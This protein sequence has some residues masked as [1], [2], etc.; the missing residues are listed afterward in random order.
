M[1]NYGAV[2]V[3]GFP[4]KYRFILI[5]FLL[6]LTI[7]PCVSGAPTNPAIQDT[8]L[9]ATNATPMSIWAA[10]ALIGLVLFLW[11][12]KARMLASELEADAIISIL[13]WIPLGYTVPTSFAVDRLVGVFAVRGSTGV[14]TMMEDHIVYSFPII[15]IVYGILTFAAV[16]NTMRILSLHKRLSSGINEKRGDD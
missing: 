5:L 12:L 1:T 10:T 7:V 16:L 2:S 9:D 3:S 11:T 13:A 14:Y 15:G 4:P 6:F 8:H